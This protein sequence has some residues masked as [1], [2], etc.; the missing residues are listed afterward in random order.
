VTIPSIFLLCIV[1]LMMGAADIVF[2]LMLFR[3]ERRKAYR[4]LLLLLAA[5]ALVFFSETVDF[6]FRIVPPDPSLEVESVLIATL[7][8]YYIGFAGILYF[9][10]SLVLELMGPRKSAV[11][12][13]VPFL[14]LIVPAGAV[15]YLLTGRGE[16]SVIGDVTMTVSLVFSIVLCLFPTG[17]DDRKIKTM[18]V[19]GLGIVLC[20]FFPVFILEFFVFEYM[21]ALPS[22]LSDTPFFFTLFYLVFAAMNL[23]YLPRFLSALPF[24]RPI[25][26]TSSFADRYA[27]SDRE[28]TILEHLVQG[29]SNKEIGY[30]L[31]ISEKTVKNH[32]FN[33]YQK[34]G[35]NSRMS[36]VRK[37]QNWD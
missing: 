34:M 31:G 33:A 10:P 35:I 16:I 26:L 32:L 12:R 20:I 37:L 18:Y 25:A 2:A 29:E 36:F 7:V 5:T 24:G 23:A 30:H 11:V 14:V 6:F 1:A 3:R 15:L 27:L 17:A 4:S 22:F 8:G 21:P 19:R 28:R 13:S 9:L